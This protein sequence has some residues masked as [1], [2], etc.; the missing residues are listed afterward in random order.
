MRMMRQAIVVVCALI[1]GL[2][3]H[4]ALSAQRTVALDPI[5]GTGRVTY[6][7]GEGT[8]ESQYRPQD[9]E[10]AAWALAAWARSTGGAIS[11]IPIAAN[12]E[13]I[14]SRPDCHAGNPS[15]N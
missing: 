11:F 13:G 7:I 5:D 4:A 1:A 3:A 8:P 14:I 15:P 12:A 2:G 9:R 6:F 10:L